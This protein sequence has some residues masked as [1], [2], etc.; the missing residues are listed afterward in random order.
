MKLGFVI[1]PLAGIGGAVALKGSDGKDIVD[2]AMSRGARPQAEARAKLAMQ[3]IKTDNK[4]SI[5]TAANS[6][7]ANTLKS[8]DLPFEVIYEATEHSSAADTK[9]IVQLFVDKQV[10]F[11]V[12]AGGDGTARDVL[13]VLT[14]KSDCTIPVIGIPALLLFH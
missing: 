4:F 12:F 10:D 7:G 3:Q 11:I 9:N 14:A 6:M 1:N 13:D 5:F 2:Q 8:L